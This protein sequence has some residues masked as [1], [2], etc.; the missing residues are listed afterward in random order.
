[1]LL[2][3]GAYGLSI[4]F[5]F[6]QFTVRAKNIARDADYDASGDYFEAATIMSEESTT[7]KQSSVNSE[8]NTSDE[9]SDDGVTCSETNVT[10]VLSNYELEN[11]VLVLF[12]VNVS[13]NERELFQ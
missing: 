3:K 6:N 9:N 4:I 2:I 1:M 12:K 5:I 11:Y 8:S 7:T 13:A 10:Q